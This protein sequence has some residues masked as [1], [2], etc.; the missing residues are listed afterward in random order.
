L[1]AVL[2][3]SLDG[4]NYL[5]KKYKIKRQKIE[6]LPLGVQTQEIKCFPTGEGFLS[7]L[8]VSFLTEVKRIDKIISAL[9][10]LAEERGGY[11]IRWRHIGSGP[12]LECLNKYA[13]NELSPL[14]VDWAFLGNM[15]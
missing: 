1:D 14:G 7:I 11:E 8:S 4:A 3:I 6:V 2:P 5:E 15:T 10:L 13:N 9:R 12:L